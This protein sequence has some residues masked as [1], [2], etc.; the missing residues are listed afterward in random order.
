MKKSTLLLLALGLLL[1][2]GCKKTEQEVAQE[3]EAETP[4]F[5]ED[6]PLAV[7]VSRVRSYYH[8]QNIKERLAKM[9]AQPYVVASNDSVAGGKW[10]SILVGAK[11]DSA[12][13]RALKTELQMK[14][15]LDSLK[16]VDYAAAKNTQ[17]EMTTANEPEAEK[18][19]ID[20]DQPELPPEVFEVMAK[21]PRSNMFFVERLA[22]LNAPDVGEEQDMYA[23][24]EDAELDLPRG[25]GASRLLRLASCFA[26]A[27]YRDNIY[28]DRVTLDIIKLKSDHGL[29]SEAAD[30]TASSLNPAQRA[31]AGHFANLV[32]NTGAYPT[33][34]KTEFTVRAAASF[35]GYR[36]VIEP[37]PGRLRTYLMLVDEAGEY[38]VFCQSTEKSEKDLEE[39]LSLLGKSEGMRTYSE[40]YNTFYT[41]PSALDDDDIFVGF[42]IDKL[43]WSYAK[44][45]DYKQWAKE[46][47]GHWSAHG[48]FYNKK[49]GPWTYGIF[50]LLTEERVAQFEKFYST[51]ASEGKH[52]VRVYGEDGY[53]I[54]VQTYDFENFEMRWAPREVNFTIG[55]Y[56]C[57]VDNY[58]RTRLSRDKLI[59]KA[60]KFQFH[61]GGYQ[62]VGYGGAG[63]DSSAAR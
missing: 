32:L 39:M 2:A 20:A 49:A 11:K 9:G 28:D 23:Q 59:A 48:L 52:Q 58:S 57:M 63:Q 16:V 14:F 38:A 21:F 50:D 7:E 42:Y 26:E 30:T 47:V 46:C 24:A 4:K 61:R 29:T 44:A 15:K 51:D 10:Y 17:L 5:A 6:K 56:V 54:A 12:E 1:M 8:A 45:K 18:R 60:E 27:V 25:I 3:R 35:A 36:T 37:K 41:L 53:F 62:E 22:V 13:L 55:R 43:D 34:E 19:N 33:E 40:F 31:V